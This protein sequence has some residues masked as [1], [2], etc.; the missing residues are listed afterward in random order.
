MITDKNDVKTLFMITLSHIGEAFSDSLMSALL[1]TGLTN[2]TSLTDALE[3][4][5]R[6]E[7]IVLEN[8]QGKTEKI[9]RLSEKGKIILPELELLLPPGVAESAKRDT[10]RF[11]EEII[12]GT[13]YFSTLKK[14]AD[15]FTLTC[16]Q[17]EKRN[18]VCNISLF[19][20]DEKSAVLAKKNF[21]TRPQAVIN[22]VKAS[23]T[24]NVDFIM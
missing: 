11:Y 15:G 6:D 20:R 12:S 19:F 18:A 16:T 14:E 1:D 21:E 7:L 17:T 9:C 4:L 10:R 8:A 5:I 24:G 2:I 22:A 23:I 13:E 3:E